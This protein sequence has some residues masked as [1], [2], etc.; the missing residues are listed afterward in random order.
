MADII[1]LTCSQCKRR[2][3]TTTV[4]K[5]KQAKKLEL[6]KYCKWCNASTLHKESK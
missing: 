1:G 3:Y 6:K 2:N 4:N 5:K